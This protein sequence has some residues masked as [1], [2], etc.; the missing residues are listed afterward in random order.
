MTTETTMVTARSHGFLLAA[1]VLVVAAG[2]GMKWQDVQCGDVL[3]ID[4]GQYRLSG[5]LVCPG[6]SFAAVTITGEGVHF[7]L[8]G[9]TITRD[10]DSGANLLAGILVRGA[11]AHINNG[12][13]VDINCPSRLF[14]QQDCTAI[15]LVEAPGARING[16]SLHNNTLGIGSWSF[17][18]VVGNADGARI[19]GND[20]TGNLR[21][22]IVLSGFGGATAE[23]AVI[24]GNDLSDTGG[25][26]VQGIGYAGTTDGVSVIGNVA[27]SCAATGIVLAGDEAQGTAERNTIRDNT[28]LD[29]GGR[30][31]LIAARTEEFR[32]RDNLIQ[33]NTSFGNGIEDLTEAI[34][35][36]G[37]PYADCLNTW[38]DNDFDVAAPDCI[39]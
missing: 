10:D 37:P 38:K 12:S 15:A 17:G 27:N 2:M 29:N 25:F 16:M 20:I 3:D 18:D 30:G 34:P 5:D 35:A 39:E 11:N 36:E 4:R 31:I 6:G 32:P 22:G 24:S 33:S 14:N 1:L 7:N 8:N 21:I 9:Y 26:P 23:G 19:H 28:T 13:I